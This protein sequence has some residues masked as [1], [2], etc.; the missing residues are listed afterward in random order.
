VRDASYRGFDATTDLGLATFGWG[1]HLDAALAAL[2]VILRGTF[3]RHPDLQIVLG[4]WGE[5]LLFWLDRVDSLARIAGLERSVS[6][7]IRSNFFITTSGMLNPALL[8]HALSVTTVERLIF[9][10]D[11]P[12]LRPTREEITTFLGHFASDA[13]REKFSSA[14]AAK[15]FGLNI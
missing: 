13:E 3:D 7:Y 10:T 5:M 14:N 2:R 6:D 1:W 8:Q 12:F 9:S 15:L 11:Y 4:H